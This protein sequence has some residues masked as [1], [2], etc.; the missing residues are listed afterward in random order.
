MTAR[1]ADGSGRSLY[2]YQ[3][4][5]TVQSVIADGKFL[6]DD[7]D[8]GNGDIWNLETYSGGDIFLLIA[9]ISFICLGCWC[10]GW[11]AHKRR[12]AAELQREMQNVKNFQSSG[13]EQE[14][15]KGL[16]ANS[17]QAFFEKGISK[18]TSR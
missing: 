15:E 9:F 5:A 17:Q 4:Q 6:S 2:C 1:Y 3:V 10:T 16:M 7:V 13:R 12:F 14:I 18:F 8:I 11:Y